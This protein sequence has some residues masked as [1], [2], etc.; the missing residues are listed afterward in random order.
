MTST[1]L[2]FSARR[3]TSAPDIVTAASVLAGLVAAD[4]GLSFLK[5]GTRPQAGPADEARSLDPS[6]RCVNAA[7]NKREDVGAESF[8]KLRITRDARMD[9]M[10]PRQIGQRVMPEPGRL[11][12]GVLARHEARP[13]R[14]VGETVKPT[15]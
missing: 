1:P 4:M 9:R 2:S 12:L 7:I 3:T 13:L 14:R 11:A 15:K 5:N 6:L 10:Q 8:R